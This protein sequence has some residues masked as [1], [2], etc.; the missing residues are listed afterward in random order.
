VRGTGGAES[1]LDGQEL[2]ARAIVAGGTL[3]IE[4][5]AAVRL[6]RGAPIQAGLRWH[7]CGRALARDVTVALSAQL[8]VHAD[9][10]GR[11]RVHRP[12]LLGEQEGLLAGQATRTRVRAFIEQRLDLEAAGNNT[13]QV[14]Q[15]VVDH[16]VDLARR[17]IPGL[18]V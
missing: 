2:T 10:A 3:A 5:G 15:A 17:D 11:V 8:V 14:I 9:Q 4:V 18:M 7:S 16:V 12:R 1:E 13:L 6:E